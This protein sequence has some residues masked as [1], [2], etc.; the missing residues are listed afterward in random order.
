MRVYYNSKLAKVLTFI[1]GFGTM[2]FFGSVIT[3]E[4]SLSA[5][6]MLH[7]KVHTKQYSNCVML[8]L[9]VAIGTMFI[10]FGFEVHSWWMLLLILVPALL[11]YLLY[12]LEYLYW[13]ICK[14]FKDA[15]YFISFE[16]Q[17]YWI[18]NS[19]YLPAD[20]QRPYVV[21]GWWKKNFGVKECN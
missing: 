16:K 20:K 4:S 17:A 11:Y 18:S 15:Y 7:E 3:E 14:G 5:E 2:M 19:W 13:V 10:L 9:A 12:F 21:F 8:G 1:G 6:V